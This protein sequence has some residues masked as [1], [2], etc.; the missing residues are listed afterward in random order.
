MKLNV[1]MIFIGILT[2]VSV[3]IADVVKPVAMGHKAIGG[4]DIVGTPTHGVDGGKGLNNIGLL[5]KTWGKVTYKDP[6]GAFFYFDDGAGIQDGTKDSQNHAIKGIR[7]GID[8]LATGNSISM[9]NFVAGQTFVTVVG[10]ISTFADSNLKIHPKLR[11]RDQSDIVIS[12]P[13]SPVNY[14]SLS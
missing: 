2:I 13:S 5:V 9:T 12:A 14:K 10:V 1:A 8:S 4:G 11:P 3:V 7:V 6:G